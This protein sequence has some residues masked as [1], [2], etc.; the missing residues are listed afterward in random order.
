MRNFVRACFGG[1]L[2]G[3]SGILR[4]SQNKSHGV[5]CKS[6]AM[7]SSK[8][9]N[10]VASEHLAGVACFSAGYRGPMFSVLQ[11]IPQFIVKFNERECV[12]ASVPSKV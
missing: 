10:Q 2:T 8:Q 4:V 6:V 3:I 7:L 5:A 1:E 9:V 12:R 11:E